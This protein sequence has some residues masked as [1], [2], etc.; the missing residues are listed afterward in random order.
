MTTEIAIMNKSAVALAADSAVTITLTGPQGREH[1]I[2]NSANKLFTLSKYCP[3]G[4]MTYGN[5]SLMGIPWETIIKVYRCNL[6]ERKFDYLKGY[7][8]HFFKFLDKFDV[9][10]KAEE[11]YVRDTAINIFSGIRHELDEFVKQ[12]AKP[13]KP[14]SEDEVINQFQKI[15]KRNHDEIKNISK[16]S[17]LTVQKRTALNKKYSKIINE[18]IDAIFEKLPL[19]QDNKTKLANTV[20]NAASV[21]PQ[22]QSGIVIAGF[23][24]KE[25]FPACYDFDIAAIFGGNTIKRNKKE[26][27]ITSENNAVVIPFAQSDEVC[28]FMEGVGRL[29]NNFFIKTF[30]S[31]MKKSFPQNIASA[32]ADKFKLND[33]QKKEVQDIAAKMGKGAYDNIAQNLNQLKHEKYIQP[34]VQ[35]TGFLNKGELATMAETLVNLVSFRKQVTLEAETV[36]GPIDVAVITKGDGFIWIQRKHY[37]DA[38][39]NHQFF[40]NYFS[41]GIKNDQEKK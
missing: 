24:E 13:D 3:V 9:G 25:I 22:N 28:T 6:G 2:Y 35:A 33:K 39:L 10:K 4:I 20:I 32:L 19:S 26:N 34:V 8:D 14:L 40:N 7:S 5:A 31:M 41:E 29:I 38:S 17:V 15:I 11:Q 16:K 36:G 1:K 27:Q 30:S 18:V 37:F 12:N 21:G 23:G